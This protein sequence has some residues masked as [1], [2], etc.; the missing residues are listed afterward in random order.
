M[1]TPRVRCRNLSIKLLPA[2]FGAVRDTIMRC[3]SRLVGLFV[4]LC[5]T[6]HVGISSVH[7]GG[8]VRL[9]IGLARGNLI[10]SDDA[11]LRAY[12]VLR[13]A[14]EN[15]RKGLEPNV[16][17]ARLGDLRAWDE[18]TER[19]NLAAFGYTHYLVAE[20]RA[21]DFPPFG[22]SVRVVWRLGELA[23]GNS[24]P[25]SFSLKQNEA[26]W[27]ISI[28]QRLDNVGGEMRRGPYEDAT[29]ME[30]PSQSGLPPSPV[31]FDTSHVERLVRILQHV[32]PEMRTDHQY[33]VDCI[34]N[35]LDPQANGQELATASEWLMIDLSQS[36]GLP[37]SNFSASLKY[38]A[39]PQAARVCNDEKREY[40]RDR[41]YQDAH[42]SIGGSLKWHP[43]ASTPERK[44]R[45]LIDVNDRLV[46]IRK[47]YTSTTRGNYGTGA[48]E[49]LHEFCLR[50]EALQSTDAL[51]G[52]VQYIH[53]HGFKRMMAGNLARWKCDV[54]G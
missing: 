28:P 38:S 43:D 31:L 1:T 52:L 51:S 26:D 9:F 27:L 12:I 6:L 37:G 15:V 44:V 2:R 13:D 46:E 47:V 16:Q 54:Q 42:F 35:R 34:R 32:F 7:A 4:A 5:I 14:L 25:L 49:L 53:A 19:P 20:P 33:F 39:L 8:G 3:A 10:G 29:L 48:S 50:K 22:R 18:A 23:A 21:G 17:I 36:L 11:H 41:E 45:P 30:Q 24:P 40:Q